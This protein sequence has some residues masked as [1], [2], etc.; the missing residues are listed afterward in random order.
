MGALTVFLLLLFCFG[1]SFIQRVTGFGFGIFA[2]TALPFLMPSY[3]EATT[4]SSS[5][6]M[7]TSLYV[8]IQLWRYISWKKLLPILITF[9]VVS[10]FAVQRVATI[11]SSLLRKILGGTLIFVSLYFIFLSKKISVRPT[12]GIQVSMGTLSGI[13][14]GF[15]SMQGPPAVLY[16]LACTETKE[17]YVALA[18]T[19][20]FIGNLIM[21]G[22]RAYNGFVTSS[23]CWDWLICFPMVVLGNWIGGKVFDRLSAARLTKIIYVFIG[24]S[25]V[26]ALVF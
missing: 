20:F 18:Q 11:D 2:M 22:F 16:F 13:M 8:M 15:F 19:F 7:M 6:A 21:T 12:M 3:A 1:G 4:L 26:I 5:L 24:I 9:L 17:E 25:G 14:G 10:F 23:V